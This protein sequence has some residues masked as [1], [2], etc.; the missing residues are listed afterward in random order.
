MTQD[1]IRTL[2]SLRRV[3]AF[4]NA[5]VENPLLANT[6]VARRRLDRVVA[7][8]TTHVADQSAVTLALRDATQH[9]YARRETLFSSYLLP[10]SRVA[11]SEL[12]DQFALEPFRMPR[13][14]TSVERLACSARGMACAAGA[15]VADFIAAGLP[16]D[17]IERLEC[18]TDRMLDTVVARARAGAQRA[19]TTATIRTLLGEA[20]KL[21]SIIDAFVTAAFSS[22][23]GELARWHATTRLRSFRA[24][25]P[26]LT[27]TGDHQ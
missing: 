27:R 3:Q 22:N 1:Q 11:S 18:A 2:T 14:H 15:H 8:L 12:D 21:V 9:Q 10:L 24:R 7:E 25:T 19:A 26:A 13:R 6:T 16:L 23:P 17:F 20:R 5:A 4:M